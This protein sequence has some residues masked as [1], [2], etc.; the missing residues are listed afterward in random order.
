M[1][2]PNSPFFSLKQSKAEV[3]F[4]TLREFQDEKE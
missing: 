4:Q 1:E 3:P 2:D